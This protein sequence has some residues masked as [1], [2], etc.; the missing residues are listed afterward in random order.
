S[1]STEVLAA[2]A[3][4]AR[5]TVEMAEGNQ[6]SA[7]AALRSAFLTWQK[8]GAPYIAAR[9]RALIGKACHALG[10]EEG[11]MLEWQAARASFALLGAAPDLD[12]VEALLNP[13]RNSGSGVLT[14]REM[15]VLKLVAEGCT[16]KAVANQLGL[17][18][19]TVDRHLSNI[20]DKLGVSSRAAA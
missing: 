6:A 9:L 15:E 16:N 12:E 5:G 18:D 17:S 11:A 1:F 13:R 8:S 4:Q 19:K 10:D 14:A 7:I 3:A 2:L 20:F